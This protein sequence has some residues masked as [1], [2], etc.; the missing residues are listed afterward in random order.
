[1]IKTIIILSIIALVILSIPFGFIIKNIRKQNQL[2]KFPEKRKQIH[3]YP[4]K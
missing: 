4:K 2:K 3:K 1:M